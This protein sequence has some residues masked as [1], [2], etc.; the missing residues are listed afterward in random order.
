MS[1]SDGVHLNR[2]GTSFLVGNLKNQLRGFKP[3]EQRDGSKGFKRDLHGFSRNDDS[4]S[5]TLLKQLLEG[6]VKIIRTNSVLI[7]SFDI[8]LALFYIHSGFHFSSS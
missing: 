5:N 7:L 2:K 6:L 8:K 3:R 1:V 4:T